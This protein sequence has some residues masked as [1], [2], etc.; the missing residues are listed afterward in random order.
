[1]QN[2]FDI[3]LK[4]KE[5]TYEKIIEMSKNNGYTTDNLLDYDYFSN[6]YKLIA[7]DFS[8]QIG[9]ENLD[10]KQEIS[11]IGRL[12]EDNAAMFFIIEISEG[13]TVNFSRNSVCIL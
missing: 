4:S 13:T 8:K 10:L 3:A 2:F 5:K 6:D 11:F 12:D 9:S 7:V 1:M